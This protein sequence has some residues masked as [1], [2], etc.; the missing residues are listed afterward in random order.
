MMGNESGIANRHC[1]ESSATVE[2]LTDKTTHLIAA[3]YML[4]MTFNTPLA[5][6][7]VQGTPHRLYGQPNRHR[8]RAVSHAGVGC[9]K[10]GCSFTHALQ[11]ETLRVRD[12]RA[13]YKQGKHS[14][15]D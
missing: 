2:A 7:S 6:H 11:T 3:L 9:S 12:K 10:R 4:Q 5:G 8:L 14:D 13:E 15:T 1:A